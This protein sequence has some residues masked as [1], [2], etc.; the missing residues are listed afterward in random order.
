MILRGQEETITKESSPFLPGDHSIDQKP[1]T[2]LTKNEFRVRDYPHTDAL[3]VKVNV[4]G[5]TL[6]NIL[7]TESSPNILLIKPFSIMGMDRKT[8]EPAG[9]R[10]I[11]LQRKEYKCHKKERHPQFHSWTTHTQPYSTE[12][13]P[14][15]S[16]PLYSRDTYA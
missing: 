1:K 11:W 6:H 13:S 14:T 9:K 12:T 15:D 5:Y 16:M 10:S 4:V 7:D 3:V 8:L 2:T